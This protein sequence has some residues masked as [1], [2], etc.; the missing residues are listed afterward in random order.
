VIIFTNYFDLDPVHSISSV[1]SI[2]D[3]HHHRY[4]YR[5]RFFRTIVSLSYQVLIVRGCPLGYPAYCVLR[6]ICT[7][8]SSLPITF[9]SY[10]MLH[11]T[12]R[13]L[14]VRWWW[15]TSILRKTIF[16]QLNFCSWI[17]LMALINSGSWHHESYLYHLW[18]S[19][20]VISNSINCSQFLV[21]L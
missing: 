7:H 9:C 1:F 11:F 21:L 16:S 13:P 20:A 14:P 6:A 17:M 5:C 18:L 2:H 4:C 12:I 8:Q 19:N 10:G 3:Y 15:Y